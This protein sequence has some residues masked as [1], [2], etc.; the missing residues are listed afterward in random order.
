[1]ERRVVR[2]STHHCINIIFYCLCLIGLMMQITQISIPFFKFDVI[3]D[4]NVIMPEILTPSHD[5][6]FTICLNN[7]DI[8]DEDEY[9]NTNV[10]KI[11]FLTSNQRF[12]MTKNHILPPVVNQTR[13]IFDDKYCYQLND[14]NFLALYAEVMRNISTLYFLI[15]PRLPYFNFKR[16]LEYPGLKYGNH[17]LVQKL[18]TFSYTLKRLESPYSD[19]CIKYDVSRLDAII[20]C[21][22]EV[23][24]KS[25]T[26][27]KMKYVKECDKNDKSMLCFE[28]SANCEN[29]FPFSDC[30]DSAH[31]LHNMRYEIYESSFFYFDIQ[32]KFNEPSFFIESKARI[33]N[34]DYVT[35]ILGAMGSWIGFT[36][37]HIN[38]VHWLIETEQSKKLRQSS[39][40]QS[41]EINFLKNENVQLKERLSDMEDKYDQKLNTLDYDMRKVFRYIDGL[42]E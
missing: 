34:I 15:G 26:T 16:I 13:F 35:Y 8:I 14:L 10:K 1:M 42:R 17:V 24:L 23:C 11:T 31:F 12:N 40:E 36:F 30:Y 2:K 32:V 22:N 19:M 21:V 6:A 39:T 3:K 18:E 9:S 4:I 28:G 5:T 41:N 25:N 7:E 20:N 38:P 33:D 27:Y 37:L 29:L